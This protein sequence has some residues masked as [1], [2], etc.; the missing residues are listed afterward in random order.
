MDK[1]IKF[2]NIFAGLDA[3]V[4]SC[5]SSHEIN[6][7]V[8]ITLAMLIPILTGA[9][10][11]VLVADYFTH[12]VIVKILIALA[13]ILIVWMVERIIIH[14]LQPGKLGLLGLS[15]VLLAVCIG[16]V[17]STMVSLVLFRDRIEM[18]L[19]NTEQIERNAIEESYKVYETKLKA[20]VERFQQRYEDL[21]NQLNLE[22]QGLSGSG[23]YGHGPAAK[24]LEESMESARRE[25]DEKKRET[26]ISIQKIEQEKSSKLEQCN[27]KHSHAG[28]STS[29]E[30]LNKLCNP[31]T[32]GLGILLTRILVALTLILLET[33]PLFSVCGKS[34]PEYFLLA[35]Q[36]QDSNIQL[37]NACVGHEQ[38]VRL[39]EKNYELD[40]EER[41]LRFKDLCERVHDLERTYSGLAEG[42]HTLSQA[43]FN[44]SK[45]TITE[46][47]W[48]KLDKLYA[49][50][51]SSINCE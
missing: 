9:A 12:S 47:E 45:S 8:G 26:A 1:R 25:M 2:L 4:L 44:N 13:W 19:R 14:S 35:D 31:F 38:D 27:N 24:R 48:D 28:L 15:R 51:L 41:N 32:H 33:I 23:H 40:M 18:E 10:A 42:I 50:A 37:M 36:M 3:E 30:T 21:Q 34:Q 11:S 43:H 29:I 39:I 22:T 49:S 7:Y 5:C 46:N 20:E 6:S 17:V 16:L